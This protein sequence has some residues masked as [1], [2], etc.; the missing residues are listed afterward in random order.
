MDL[1]QFKLASCLGN[2]SGN[3]LT[4]LCGECIL[5]ETGMVMVRVKVAINVSP[6]EHR[7]G[8]Q[9]AG[10]TSSG[11]TVNGHEAYRL[12]EPAACQCE[13]L[14][15]VLGVIA[16]MLVSTKELDW[17]IPADAPN[18]FEDRTVLR[19]MGGH[20]ADHEK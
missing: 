6:L 1:V 7:A 15:I 5:I 4:F 8:I 9:N 11:K 17:G 19:R 2:Q 13:R 20:M 12:H 18:R 10:F 14:V 3:I 16:D